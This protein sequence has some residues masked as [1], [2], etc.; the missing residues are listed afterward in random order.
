[1]Q[2]WPIFCG[3]TAGCHVMNYQM[4][5]RRAVQGKTPGPRLHVQITITYM[6]LPSFLELLGNAPAFICHLAVPE[7]IRTPPTTEFP[8][9]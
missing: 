5:K 1:M 4:M 8:R 3:Y 2:Q 7:N 6:R 9:G